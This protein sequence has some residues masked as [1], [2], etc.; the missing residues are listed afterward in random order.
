MEGL[1][2]CHH[3]GLVFTFIYLESPLSTKISL[4]LFFTYPTLYYLKFYSFHEVFL[5]STNPFFRNMICYY[6][7]AVGF[8]RS[9]PFSSGYFECSCNM[10]PPGINSDSW[11]RG[12]RAPNS[13][14]NP[15]HSQQNSA[16]FYTQCAKY[17]LF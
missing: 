3:R 15:A 14:I 10:R 9:L 17:I 2:C 12:L 16:W 1:L 6:F 5:D 4:S 8:H 11:T 13:R 7:V